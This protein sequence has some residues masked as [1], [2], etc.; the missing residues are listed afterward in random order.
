MV[1]NSYC[2]ITSTHKVET[3]VKNDAVDNIGVIC[4]AKLCD[5]L[6][7]EAKFFTI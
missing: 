6:L 1:W 7:V 4:S 5:N 2:L 3:R